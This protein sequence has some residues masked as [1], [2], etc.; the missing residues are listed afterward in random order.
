MNGI[1]TSQ[2]MALGQNTRGPNQTFRDINDEIVIPILVKIVDNRTVASARQ[3]VL[4]TLSCERRP[5]F[6]IGNSRCRK[7]FSLFGIF[8]NISASCFLNVDFY[9]SASIQVENHR[10]SSRTISPTGFPLTTTHREAPLGFPPLQVPKPLLAS[11]LS[12]STSGCS[13]TGTIVATIFPLSV[14][15]MDRP[16]FTS[17]R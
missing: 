5:R 13:C 2:S 15:M 1:G 14:I 16:F 4:P 9:E 8:P 7:T 11:L 6:S 17:L 12:L 10:R 3:T